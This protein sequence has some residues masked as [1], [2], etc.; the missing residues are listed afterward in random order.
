[1]QFVSS[2]PEENEGVIVRIAGTNDYM[3]MPESLET[4][5]S[6]LWQVVRQLRL[7][8][9]VAVPRSPRMN[10]YWRS[11][12]G[13]FKQMSFAFFCHRLVLRVCISG[14]IEN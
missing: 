4:D 7:Q 10:A 13:L 1:M 12:V 11:A 9:R 8:V 14:T 2:P 5:N 3:S 6:P